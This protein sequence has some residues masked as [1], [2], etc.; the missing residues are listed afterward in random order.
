MIVAAM[1]TRKKQATKHEER[2][3]WQ[4]RGLDLRG[5]CMIKS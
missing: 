1:K 4:P 5:S 2:F 3:V